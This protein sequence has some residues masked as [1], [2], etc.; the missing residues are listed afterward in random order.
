[1]T[2]PLLLID[3]DGVANAFGGPFA[4]LPAPDGYALYR[5]RERSFTDE[6]G[7]PWVQ[8]GLRVWLNPDHGRML[9]TLADR[10]ELAWCT[11]WRESANEFISPVLGLPELPVVPLPGGWQTLADQHWKTPG[12][13]EYAAGR[14]LAW[15]DDEFKAADYEWSAKR[16]IDGA[17][18]LLVP[19]DP[20]HG[21][22]QGDIDTV[23]EWSS[24]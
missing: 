16:T 22:R 5:L 6:Q 2:K 8:G 19:I 15:F 23:A 14:A 4:G 10:F 3:V 24:R 21:I 20:L 7:R 17:P 12:V 9:L 18:T 11:A 1:M 13:E